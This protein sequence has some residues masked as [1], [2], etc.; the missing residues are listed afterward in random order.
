M[1]G[2]YFFALSPFSQSGSMFHQPPLLSVCY[3]SLLFVFQF[4]GGSLA[5]DAAHWFKK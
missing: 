3:D 2:V 4:L 1:L 5:L